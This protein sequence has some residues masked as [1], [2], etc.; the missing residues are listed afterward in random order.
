MPLVVIDVRTFKRIER[1][2]DASNISVDLAII[3][4]V[5]EWFDT[6]G[7]LLLEPLETAIT[8]THAK[9]TN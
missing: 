4:A 6:T 3:E 7:K 2:A 9:M 8:S 1:Y 5:N